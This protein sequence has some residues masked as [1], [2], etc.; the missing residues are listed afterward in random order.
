[1]RREGPS[2][3]ALKGRGGSGNGA[4]ES[5]RGRV[6]VK[7]SPDA[8]VR[9]TPPT[10]SP[11]T[12]A[13]LGAL[14][15][16][17]IL[18]PGLIAHRQAEP[19]RAAVDGPGG[20]GASAVFTERQ[21][22]F[23]TSA[24]KVVPLLGGAPDVPAPGD[25]GTSSAAGGQAASASA[26]GA[27]DADGS[28]PS[29]REQKPAE[30]GHVEPEAEPSSPSSASANAAPAELPP[31]GELDR[32]LVRVYLTEEKR[33]EKVPMELYV[34]GVLAGEMP[35]GFEP[36]A[37]KAQAI[38]ARTYIVKRLAAKDRSGVPG[39]A[40]DVTDTTAH[41]VYVPLAELQKRWSG[42]ER[43]RN[44][45]KLNAAVQQTRGQIVTYE[46]KPIEALFFSTSNGY[47]ENS[48]DY[49]DASLPYLRS[50]ASPWDKTISPEYKETTTMSL[51]AFWR[52]LGVS[53]KAGARSLRV[54]DTT[55]GRRIRKLAA[56][57]QVL[58]GR[59]VREKLGLPSTQFTWKVEGGDIEITTYGYGHGVGMSQWGADGMAKAGRSA[60]QIL[61][62]YYTGTEVV[63][64][65]S[66]PRNPA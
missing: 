22:T 3:G 56:G 44:L 20:Y 49:W 38:A 54:L 10:P 31:L 34:R 25:G 55:D 17:A 64:T 41:Q 19:E 30:A 53:S 61:S 27:S 51:A 60:Y 4:E 18:L 1:M 11:W 23:T 9:R 58:T 47:T 16:A 32:M 26:P 66:L 65:A 2:A 42:E 15:A 48:E 52:K 45:A 5:R 24:G 8:A 29:G 33:V 13:A 39:G 43:E 62:H 40:A 37:L 46:G 50:V 35:I 7:G 14:T 28:P 6:P 57:G 21:P 12:L 59:E 36:E 63:R